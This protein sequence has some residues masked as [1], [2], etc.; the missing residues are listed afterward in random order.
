MIKDRLDTHQDE[1]NAVYWLA[2]RATGER[3]AW[4]SLQ[5]KFAMLAARVE[6][7]VA[8]DADAELIDC[9]FMYFAPYNSEP[10]R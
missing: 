6:A 2:M 9:A 8:S 7:L 5:K 10:L 3:I 1:L 4:A